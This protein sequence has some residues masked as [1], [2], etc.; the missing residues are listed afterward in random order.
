MILVVSLNNNYIKH[1]H[2]LSMN[3]EK[4]RRKGKYLSLREIKKRRREGRKREGKKIFFMLDFQ[5]EKN[6]E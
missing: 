1:S 2:T 5:S 3:R 4:M 6:P